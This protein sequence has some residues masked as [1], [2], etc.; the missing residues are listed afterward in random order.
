[1]RSTPR[2]QMESCVHNFHSLWQSVLTSLTRPS[3]PRLY[4][5][6]LVVSILKLLCGLFFYTRIPLM[7]TLSTVFLIYRQN[8][9]LFHWWANHPRNHHVTRICCW[10]WGLWRQWTVSMA[11]LILSHH[12]TIA[13]T[14]LQ[15]LICFSLLAWD[16]VLF[17][18]TSLFGSSIIYFTVIF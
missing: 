14:C 3:P 9:S 12:R 1:M 17:G 15:P 13:S 2:Y 8:K 4:N 16:S 5:C 6:I 11:P 18:S 10:I 7:I